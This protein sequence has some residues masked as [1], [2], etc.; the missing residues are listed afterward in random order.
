MLK[1]NNIN[2][3]LGQIIIIAE[4]KDKE[5]RAHL[6]SEHRAQETIGESSL[7]HHL[8]VLKTELEDAIKEYSVLE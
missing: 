8:K 4:L 6:I 7:V 1:L 5:D 2:K 3:L